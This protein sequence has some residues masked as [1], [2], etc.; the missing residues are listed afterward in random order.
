MKENLRAINQQSFGLNDDFI[1]ICE[2]CCKTLVFMD[3]GQD[4]LSEK[5]SFR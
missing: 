4:I 1:P 5:Q 3:Y 2:E